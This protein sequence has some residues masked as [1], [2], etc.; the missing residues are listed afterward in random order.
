[1]HSFSE[2]IHRPLTANA[3]SQQPSGVY[4]NG[5]F[6]VAI[7]P[8]GD[9]PR[10]T[11][12]L[13]YGVPCQHGDGLLSFDYWSTFENVLLK[14]CTRLTQERRCTSQIVYPMDTP[15]VEVQVVNPAPD[16]PFSLE[17]IVSGFFEP[18]VFLIDNVTYDAHL[19]G[20]GPPAYVNM[21]NP[22][23]VVQKQWGIFKT[24]GKLAKPLPSNKDGI[25]ALESKDGD[26]INIDK[27]Q[28]TTLRR[29][30]PKSRVY[31]QRQIPVISAKKRALQYY[32]KGRR[33]ELLHFQSQ[34]EPYF[35]GGSTICYPNHAGNISMEPPQRFRSNAQNGI[36]SGDAGRSAMK[37]PIRKLSACE[38]LD[39][40][41]DDGSLCHYTNLRRENVDQETTAR[42]GNWRF[43]RN[44]VSSQPIELRQLS[45][46]LDTFSAL[47]APIDIN[48]V[49]GGSDSEEQQKSFYVSGFVLAGE[50][51]P[52]N[53]KASS[54]INGN[55]GRRSHLLR[56]R[57]LYVLESP[58]FSLETDGYSEN[59]GSIDEKADNTFMKFNLYQPS[60]AISLQVCLNDLNN[61][62]YESS[63]VHSKEASWEQH[64]LSIPA[65]TKKIYFVASQWKRFKWLA[66]D[67]IKLHTRCAKSPEND[68]IGMKS[69]ETLNRAF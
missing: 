61:C 54:N 16:R 42:F 33:S 43:T 38:L 17:I 24:R 9:D 58:A 20:S 35:C 31:G 60:N 26:A 69:S 12:I 8:T 52:N 2:L 39:C 32:G 63:T 67:N 46:E 36:V 15:R 59:S 65:T 29:M 37:L 4:P 28:Q 49:D 7:E 11:A 45:Q 21:K 53:L 56:G 55:F 19:C 47:N 41:F 25:R 18:A 27:M 48:V 68:E 50:R 30:L 23:K 6:L 51:G 66:I 13:R 10:K 62:V 40:S 5:A 22:G 1:M 14:V 3:V 34:L 57:I 64:S 44:E